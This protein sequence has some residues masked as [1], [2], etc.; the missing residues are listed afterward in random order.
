M[1]GTTS[2]CPRM[3]LGWG[4]ILYILHRAM[5]E[6]MDLGDQRFSIA[7]LAF[8]LGKGMNEELAEH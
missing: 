3:L 1:R 8:A 7:Q 4:S 6:E 5:S 2:K